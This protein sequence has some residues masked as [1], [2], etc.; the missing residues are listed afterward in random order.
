MLLSVDVISCKKKLTTIYA[1]RLC[2]AFVIRQ[3]Q[4]KIKGDLD[5]ALKASTLISH[6]RSKIYGTP[7]PSAPVDDKVTAAEHQRE[8]NDSRDQDYGAGSPAPV[9]DR[10]RL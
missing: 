10:A 4:I 1:L 8:G 7:A 3:K 9:P 5:R 2:Y 6:E